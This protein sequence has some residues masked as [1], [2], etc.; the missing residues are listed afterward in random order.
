MSIRSLEALPGIYLRLTFHGNP[1]YSSK[2]LH[3]ERFKDW[4][5]SIQ[6]IAKN[7]SRFALNGPEGPEGLLE[8]SS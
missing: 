5:P 3:G 2:V 8:A 6:I 1:E 7:M 4:S